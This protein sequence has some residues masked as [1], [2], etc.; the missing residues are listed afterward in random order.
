MGK[1]F[2]T[3][4]NIEVADGKYIIKS[5]AMREYDV[6]VLSYLLTNATFL[7][8]SKLLFNK[9]AEYVL[10]LRY[11]PLMLSNYLDNVSYTQWVSNNMDN[12]RIG[13]KTYKPANDEYI[14]GVD[15][16][17]NRRLSKLYNC[18]SIQ[19]ARITNDFFDYAPYTKI[20]VYLPY[21]KWIELDVNEVMGKYLT[22]YFQI[23]F[24]TGQITWYITRKN[25][26]T[27]TDETYVLECSGQIG[28]DVP[29]GSTNASEVARNML[30]LAFQTGI[31]AL[32]L[33][34]SGL[35]KGVA[36]GMMGVK[37]IGMLGNVG[38]NL[39]NQLQEHGA[40]PSSLQGSITNLRSP[41]S[42]IILR[43]RL[44]PISA[45]ANYKHLIG[46]PLNTTENLSDL[47]GY[48]EIG[49]IHFDPMGE[50]IYQD[51]ITEIVDLLQKGVVF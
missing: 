24:Y 51:E 16:Q 12:I 33:K 47:S 45:D 29:I 22:F 23:D 32:T 20:R 19:I 6:A 5:Y 4:T 35:I 21:L 44:N 15:L 1:N 50:S 39:L 26:S 25:T 11:Y 10:N 31:S 3:S 2:V 28:I 49:V 34:A 17:K 27:S 48:A 42:I 43:E 41:T 14:V 8:D 7:N 37:A 18:G 46:L 38:G 30:N 36:G 13:G 9:P 40:K